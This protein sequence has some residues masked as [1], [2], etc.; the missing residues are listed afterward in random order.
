MRNAMLVL[1]AVF[2]CIVVGAAWYHLDRPV[3]RYVVT[4]ELTALEREAILAQVGRV[5]GGILSVD[6]AAIRGQFARLDWVREASVRRRWPDSLEI[7]VARE[8]AIARWGDDAYVT[9]SGRI[10]ALP[11]DY[12]NL[13]TFRVALSPPERALQTYGFLQQVAGRAGLVV[14]ELKQNQQGEWQVRFDNGMWVYLGDQ[15]LN[16]R[17][18]RVLRLYRQRLAGAPRQIAYIDARYT[19]GAAVKLAA[20]EVLLT[21]NSS[22]QLVQENR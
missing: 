10:L 1:C 21:G 2:V 22:T 8:D 7:H 9:V 6:L 18:H 20:A 12:D 13:P 14:D 5:E 3:L 16:E 19:N 4:G 15:E 11:D 17:M